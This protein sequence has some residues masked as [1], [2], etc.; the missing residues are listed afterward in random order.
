ML[1]NQ[2]GFFEEERRLKLLCCVSDEFEIL[3]EQKPDWDCDEWEM[4]S[5]TEYFCEY[6]RIEGT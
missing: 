6:R 3:Q 2:L 1:E 5:L 4:G